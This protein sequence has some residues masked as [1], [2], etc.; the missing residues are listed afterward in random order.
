MTD[1]S[2]ITVTPG[3]LPANLK[4]SLADA[5]KRIGGKLID[6]VRIDTTHFV[7]TEGRGPAWEKAVEMNIPVVRPEWVEGCER[8]GTIVSVRG[9]YLNADPK[10]RQIGPGVGAHQ[11]RDSAVTSN[12]ASRPSIQRPNNINSN[13]NSNFLAEQ[14][15]LPQPPVTPFPGGSPDETYA[16][17]SS[18]SQSPPPPPPKGAEN[19]VRSSGEHEEEEPSPVKEAQEQETLKLDS[20]QQEKVEEPTMP[21]P[22]FTEELGDEEQDT[23]K[24][25]QPP[26]KLEKVP[27][28]DRSLPQFRQEGPKQNGT[29]GE[30]SME[31]V[32]L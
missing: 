10:L 6:T 29:G 32:P 3:V 27:S 4:D 13:T 19:G 15:D 5:V 17:I 26:S 1:L 31:E 14:K 30:G 9:Y 25:S 7:C 23:P 24:P 22:K 18:E 2:G 12:S 28:T 11:H 21:F 8:E 20:P 16:Q